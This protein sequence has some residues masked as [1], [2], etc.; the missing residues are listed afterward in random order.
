MAEEI[1]GSLVLG[2]NLWNSRESGE[3]VSGAARSH[4]VEGVIEGVRL[5][6]EAEERVCSRMLHNCILTG[7]ESD[8]RDRGSALGRNFWAIFGKEWRR[9]L[10]GA[11]S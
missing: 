7:S 6:I 11:L 3:G 5:E 2:G 8:V 4:G 1:A 10:L 9:R